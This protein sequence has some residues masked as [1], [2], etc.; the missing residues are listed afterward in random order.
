M[1]PKTKQ[2]HFTVSLFAKVLTLLLNVALFSTYLIV[3]NSAALAIPT[4]T[5]VA[6]GLHNPRGLNFAPDGSLYVVEAGANSPSPS[7]CGFTANGTTVCYATSGSITR[8][9][10]ET[11]VSERIID[12]LPALISPSGDATAALGVHDI[13]F[14]GLGN[15]YV[16]IGLEGNP[17][18]RIANFGENGRDFARLARFNP[19]GKFSF[20]EDL[21]AYE[22]DVNPDGHAVAD[23]N[24]YGILALP[25]KVVYTDAS[26]NALN[27]VTAKGDISTL[28]VFPDRVV[29][30]PNGTMATIQAVPSSVA[31]GPDGNYYVGQVTGFPFTVGA[32]NVYRVPAEGGAPEIAFSGFT[33]IID[34]AFANDGSLYVLEISKDGIPNFNPGRLVQIAPDGTRTEI[35]AGMLRAPGGVA[36]GSDGALYVTNKSVNSTAGEVLRIEL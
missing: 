5:V 30:R 15:A 32:A 22:L 34:V 10:F 24:P 33:N 3:G 21:G 2:N 19:S 7:P 16:S 12:S 26:G 25:G 9:D 27:Q 28:A 1:Y 11:G 31:L 29:T 13:S 35:A 23:S 8:I 36:I 17:A 18:L 20:E 6:A 14:Q 4:V